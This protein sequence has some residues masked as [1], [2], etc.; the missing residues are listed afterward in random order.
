LRA[1]GWTKLRSPKFYLWF[2]VSVARGP[3]TA[4]LKAE[5][6]VFIGVKHVCVVS[7]C[8]ATLH[9]LADG[10]DKQAMKR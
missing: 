8:T 5:L 10:G 9:G 1:R 3:E 4:G 6:V 7:S 2:W